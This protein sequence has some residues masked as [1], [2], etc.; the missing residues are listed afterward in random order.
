MA[1]R[2]FAFAELPWRVRLSCSKLSQ[3][4][5]FP[6]AFAEEDMEKSWKSPGADVSGARFKEV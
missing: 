5:T 6:V 2:V 4:K 3:L 1:W